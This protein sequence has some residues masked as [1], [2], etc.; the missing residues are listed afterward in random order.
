M[1]LLEER[2]KVRPPRLSHGFDLWRLGPFPLS[3]FT[4]HNFTLSRCWRQKKRHV[5]S[6]GSCYFIFS[7]RRGG[8]DLPTPVSKPDTF[9]PSQTFICVPSSPSAS[10]C[11]PVVSA[12]SYILQMKGHLRARS[13]PL[14]HAVPRVPGRSP[15]LWLLIKQEG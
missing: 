15:V 11:L 13:L 12:V 9:I 1:P 7:E 4:L 6:P 5:L 10:M 8:A 2:P 14:I 3:N